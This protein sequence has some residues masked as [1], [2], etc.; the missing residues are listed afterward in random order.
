MNS[1]LILF[2]FYIQACNSLYNNASC[3]TNKLVNLPL[4]LTTWDFQSAAVAGSL[5]SKV[6]AYK[7][8]CY[9]LIFKMF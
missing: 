6:K 2:I 7:I 1:I 5:F 3:Q 4:V 9:C 8:D